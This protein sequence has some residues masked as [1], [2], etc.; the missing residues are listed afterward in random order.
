[1]LRLASLLCRTPSAPRNVRWASKKLHKNVAKAF[2]KTDLDPTSSDAIVKALEAT[3]SAL[4]SSDSRALNGR[5]LRDVLGVLMETS[6]PLLT[7]GEEIAFTI[8]CH[9]SRCDISSVDY[10]RIAF[11]HC[12][13]SRAVAVNCVF[14]ECRFVG[15]SFEGAVLK[16]ST[17]R[18]CVFLDCNFCFATL[19]NCDC[20]SAQFFRCDFDL[21]DMT[22][23]STNAATIFRDCLNWRTAR[24]DD[25]RGPRP[26]S[27]DRNY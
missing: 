21:C 22:R 20:C 1:M 26:K 3:A 23:V 5:D 16:N 13:M 25:W 7:Q 6:S 2:A 24:R 10:T 27:R 8:A 15:V 4:R 11:N 9:L 14:N 18:N 12:D 19:E 17:F